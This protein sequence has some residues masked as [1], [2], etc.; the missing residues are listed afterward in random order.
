MTP[1]ISIV[2]NP[3]LLRIVRN[4]IGEVVYSDNTENL[5]SNEIKIDIQDL[6]NGLYTIQII[7]DNKQYSAKFI[8]L[9]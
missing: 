7:S 6:E 4:L 9:K 1:I 2:G 3:K 5:N 8:I